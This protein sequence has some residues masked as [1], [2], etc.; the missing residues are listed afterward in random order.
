[1]LQHPNPAQ[2]QEGV[3]EVDVV[4]DRGGK[5]HETGETEM[6]TGDESTL[7]MGRPIR[8]LLLAIQ[9]AACANAGVKPMDEKLPTCG[10]LA[11]CRTH[12][13]Q[14]VHVVAVYSVWD[15]LPERAKNHPPAQQVMLMF[16]DQEGPYLGA[17]GHDGHLRPL[18]E[19]ARLHA[20]PAGATRG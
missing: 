11:E 9:L 7:W 15:L 6:R 2:E 18:D 10:S 17:W 3:D 5:S 14:R 16:G 8:A 4:A 1:V 13:G 19:I 20:R 12:D